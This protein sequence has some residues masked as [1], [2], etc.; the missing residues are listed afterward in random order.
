[1]RQT[2]Q[3]D[4]EFKQNAVELWANS[5]KPMKQI[6]REI[7]IP[8]S[9]LKEWKYKYLKGTEGIP[10]RFSMK[11]T[12]EELAVEIRKLRQENEFLKRQKEILKK[13]LG[14]LSDQSPGSMR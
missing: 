13:A 7:G 8:S 4:E 3:Y 1:M 9:T 5:G 11:K 6:A 14:I 10:E 2:R 12:P